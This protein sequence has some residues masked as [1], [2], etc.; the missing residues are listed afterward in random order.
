MRMQRAIN[1]IQT[2]PN[3]E[4][5][6]YYYYYQKYYYRSPESEKRLKFI[7]FG[8]QKNQ[9]TSSLVVFCLGERF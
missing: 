8:E 4:K 1:Y 3:K 5:T 9:A 7:Q 6:R 2:N